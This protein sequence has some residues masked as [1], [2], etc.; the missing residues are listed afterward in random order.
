MKRDGVKIW[1]SMLE[2]VFG[3]TAWREFEYTVKII[4][5][6]SSKRKIIK[7]IILVKFDLD[8]QKIVKTF[9]EESSLGSSKKSLK[10]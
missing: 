8:C 3:R 5:L 4:F 10:N 9:L 2:V 1:K 7:E 6:D